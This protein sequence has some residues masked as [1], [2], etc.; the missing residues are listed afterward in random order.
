MTQNLWIIQWIG[1]C[2]LVRRE[3]YRMCKIASQV[4]LPP[5][6]TTFLYQIIFG[7][8]MTQRIGLING[9]NYISFIAP[10][11]IMMAV[12]INSY[13]NVS[14]SLFLLR[15]QKSIEE[16]LVSPLHP[17]LMLLGFCIGG[18]LRGIVVA[19]L[20]LL[21]FSFFEPIPWSQ[22]LS[23]LGIVSL[24]A[25]LF[26]LAG[27]TNAILARTFDDIALVPTFLLTPLSYLGG[28][29]YT[30]SMLP[31]AWQHVIDYNPIFYMIN[32]LR[33]VMIGHQ[34]VS[35]YSSLMVI[36]GLIAVFIGVN[37]ILLKK[38]TGLRA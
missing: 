33:H 13:S 22:V 26:S 9:H 30:R 5:V 12:I 32:A 7:T 21:V 35:F 14:S 10:G 29:F 37:W 31:T 8:I 18:I 28:V 19:L 15:F 16:I 25:L 20:V 23:M 24:V 1:F 11:L 36:L 27:F 17:S 6:M 2:T 4:F 38:G 3:W 34:E